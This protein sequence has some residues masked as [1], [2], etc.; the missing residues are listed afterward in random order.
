MLVTEA[1]TVSR[2]LEGGGDLIEQRGDAAARG[3]GDGVLFDSDERAEP[4]HAI[5]WTRAGSR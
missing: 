4:A 2:G 1:E 5:L 3:A